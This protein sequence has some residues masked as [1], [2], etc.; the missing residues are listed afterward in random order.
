MTAYTLQDVLF[1]LLQL[2]DDAVNLYKY[3]RSAFVPL[4]ALATPID[5]RL[6]RPAVLSYLESFCT[7]SMQ[8]IAFCA[9]AVGKL[10]F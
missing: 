4:V 1:H 5:L 6:Y 7:F 9:I 2:L 8:L 10:S 3:K